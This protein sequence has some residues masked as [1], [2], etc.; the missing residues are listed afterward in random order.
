MPLKGRKTSHWSL[1][2]ELGERKYLS[3]SERRRFLDAL[4]V[5]DDLHHQTF[6]EM[7]FWSGCRPSEALDLN[8]FQIDV[9]EQAAIIRS[10]K[11]R[12]ELKGRHY[13]VVPLPSGF[14]AK[15]DQVHRLGGKQKVFTPETAPSIWRFSR[16]T[17]WRKMRKVMKAAGISG[18]HA[19]GRGLRHTYGVHAALSLVPETRV[20]SWLGHSDLSTTAI[21]MNAS[22]PEDRK[23]ASRM[24]LPER[25]AA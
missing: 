21:Y 3:E 15:L 20:Q 10:K 1:F 25:L 13:R 16:S 8:I 5:L 11:K 9:A 14:I 17:G 19:C 12:G 22:G 24:W 6:C 18:I 2:T 23:I 7:V 4:S